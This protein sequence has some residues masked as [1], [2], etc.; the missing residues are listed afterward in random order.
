[1]AG[2]TPQQALADNR[3]PAGADGGDGSVPTG[4][5]VLSESASSAPSGGSSSTSSK[6]PSVLRG[7]GNIAGK[8]IK[9]IR[10]RAGFYKDHKALAASKAARFVGRNAARAAGVAT[11][12][13]LGVAAGITGDD[14]DDVYKFGA[15][16]AALGGTMFA[17]G[18]SNAAGR[19]T[20]AVSTAFREGYY[21]DANAAQVAQAK[22][23]FMENEDNRKEIAKKFKP[24][25]EA[26]LNSLMERAATLNTQGVTD[27]KSIKKTMK[28]EN[29]IN[30]DL[31]TT[32]ADI[33]DEER[34]QL[35][36]E[37]AL[38][39]QRIA[40]SK[41]FDAKKFKTDTDYQEKWRQTFSKS[42][43]KAG[44]DG[45]NNRAQREAQSKQMLKWLKVRQGV[46]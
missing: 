19:A 39:I 45:D 44:L 10:D 4:G 15:A 21:G 38:Y 3:G 8:P 34:K 2:A 12:G 17:A 29:E 43:E 23:E 20:G 26:E 1:M 35:A 42:L 30:Q 25:N 33:P 13:A 46:D 36:F 7:I 14:L 31:A 32:N 5:P 28:L 16:G 9:T 24:N 37:Q 18:L 11:I 22:T 40:S 41:E 6:N 27:M